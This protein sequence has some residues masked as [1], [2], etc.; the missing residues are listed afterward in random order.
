M[1]IKVS[2]KILEPILV[3]VSTAVILSILL[4]IWEVT[5]DGTLITHLLNGASKT[6]LEELKKELEGPQLDP[7]DLK[8]AVIAF[9]LNDGCPNGWAK[10]SQ[11]ESRTI[12]GA[13]FDNSSDSGLTPYKFDVKGGEENIAI[14]TS[15]IPKHV[16]EFDDIYYSENKTQMRGHSIATYDVPGKIG[17]GKTDPDNT[18][19]V[20]RHYTEPFGNDSVTEFTNMPPYI[21]LYY[22]IR[23]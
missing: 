23:K 11:A 8:G 4:V 7:L 19:W 20:I 12:I 21:P 10:F 16:H 1:P 5:T 18:G 14:S 9:D 6:D 13:S 17:S 2:E 15:N 3:A 22:C